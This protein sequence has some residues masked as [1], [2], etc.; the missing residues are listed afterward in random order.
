MPLY[1]SIDS[2]TELVT[3][4]AEGAITRADTDA[5]IDAIVGA[6]ALPYRKL[7]DGLGGTLA[8]EADDL[9]EIG[10]RFRSYHHQGVGPVALV[11]RADQREVLARLLGV[12]AS[13]DRPLRLFETRGQAKRW[14]DGFSPRRR[15]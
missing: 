9:L 8:L 11:L 3:I 15:A 7:Y 6:G 2:K 10:A 12:L 4:I 1:W 5:Y 14:L 13:A